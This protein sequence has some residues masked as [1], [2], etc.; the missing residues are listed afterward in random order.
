M[1]RLLKFLLTMA[2]VAG[3]AS[4]GDSDAA[5]RKRFEDDRMSFERLATKVDALSSV[6]RLKDDIGTSA[7]FPRGEF[8]CWKRED[9]TILLLFSSAGLVVGGST[10][11]IARVPEKSRRFYHLLDAKS[12][13]WP[14]EEGEFI[15]SLDGDWFLFKEAR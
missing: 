13:D 4:G 3:C 11:G 5:L 14:Q 2:L 8:S 7:G 10:K 15:K 6:G 9:G 1:T 12:T